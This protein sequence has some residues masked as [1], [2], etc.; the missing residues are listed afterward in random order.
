M[1]C[2]GSC[3]E[4]TDRQLDDGV[5]AVEVVD[6]DTRSGLVGDKG[7]IPPVGEQ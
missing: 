1:G 4:V 7:V 2:S 3:F 5:L 6:G